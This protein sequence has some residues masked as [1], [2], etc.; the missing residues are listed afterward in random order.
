MVSLDTLVDTVILNWDGV[1]ESD[2]MEEIPNNEGK[3]L[4]KG[5]KTGL[6]SGNF[7]FTVYARDLNGNFN[8][9]ETR[10][11][12]IDRSTIFDYSDYIENGTIIQDLV[13]PAL[14]DI[15]NISSLIIFNN[16]KIT[17]N[18]A[19]NTN[20]FRRNKLQKLDSSISSL[21]DYSFGGDNITFEPICDPEIPDPQTRFIP[22]AQIRFN[23]THEQLRNLNIENRENELTVQYYNISTKKWEDVEPE[24]I[25][26]RDT[27]LNIITVNTSHLT[28]FAL[29]VPAVAIGSVGSSG[30]GGSV[31]GAGVVTKEPFENIEKFE[32]ETKDINDHSNSAYRYTF[33][34]G[35]YEIIVN[36]KNVVNDVSIRVE[37][38]K[39]LSK[40][41]KEPAPEVVH[42]YQNIWSGTKDVKDVII[43]FREDNSWINS[44]NI[45]N[46]KMLKWDGSKWI[47][48]ETKEISKD[49]TY[50][51][52]EVRSE[53]F[54]NFAVIGEKA[55]AQETIT[56][57]PEITPGETP[58]VISPTSTPGPT[59]SWNYILI[60]LALILGLI[61]VVLGVSGAKPIKSVSSEQFVVTSQEVYGGKY[62]EYLLEQYKLYVITADKIRERQ[63]YTN[64]YFLIFNSIFV[65]IF[66][67]LYGFASMTKQYMWQYLLLF[68][69]FLV[70]ITWGT[71]S[72]RSRQSNSVRL[73]LIHEIESKLPME[74]HY[75]ENKIMEE[76][77]GNPYLNYSILEQYMPWIFAGIYI[78]LMAMVLSGLL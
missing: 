8:V 75:S 16:T 28:V 69:G 54:S 64:N 33:Q 37:L 52:F 7:S 73:A 55:A 15:P 20:T 65:A 35:I 63:Q 60:V 39:G 5:N 18:C 71:F 25:I 13:I 26:S 2:P 59:V 70:S 46:V 58:P 29:A 49:D 21:I 68:A 57:T 47:D 24:M 38:L 4:Y 10:I 77:K 50:T 1:N 53:G 17:F 30:G 31:G 48:L 14:D 43:R 76:N 74:L 78:L 3:I 22:D 45:S 62:Y 51:Y 41:V 44:Q 56:P 66:G 19:N 11:V 67:V 34:Y 9:S 61:I 42:F 27:V 32:I 23:Y 6:F 72:S 40:L 36:G 12:E